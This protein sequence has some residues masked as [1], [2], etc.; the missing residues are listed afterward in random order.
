MA[1]V[2]SRQLNVKELIIGYD[3]RFGHNRQ[4][5]FEDYQRYGV[6]LGITVTRSAAFS[7][8][9]LRV[10][11]SIVRKMIEAGDLE[12]ACL[13]LGRPY[14]IEG[15]IV[16]GFRQGRKMGFP[17]AN[18]DLTSAHQLMPAHGVYAVRVQV[19]GVEQQMHGMTNIGVR[20]TF[21][22]LNLTVET[23][24]FDFTGDIYER[25]IR[26]A[27]ITRVREERKF[28]GPGELVA[29]L[30]KDEAQI[31]QLFNSTKS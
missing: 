6:E 27:F 8:D 21:G 28:S 17:T 24:I 23:Y 18:L 22:G 10:S 5:G 31:R 1:E 12:Q 20:P 26:L 3:N 15:K 25:K 29:Q 11:S 4:E 2:L 19:D 16:G 30:K 14:T 13:C 7:L 9:Q